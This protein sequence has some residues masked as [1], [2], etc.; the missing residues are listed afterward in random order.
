MTCQ[1]MMMTPMAISG[2][3]ARAKRLLTLGPCRPPVSRASRPASS[4]LRS[5]GRWVA[6]DLLVSWHGG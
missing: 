1:M 4:W 5:V 2:D 6:I 3:S